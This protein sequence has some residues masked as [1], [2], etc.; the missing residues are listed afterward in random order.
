MGQSV[1]SKSLN[2]QLA[3]KRH[4]RTLQAAV[5][6]PALHAN[7]FKFHHCLP[8]SCVLTAWLDSTCESRLPRFANHQVGVGGMVINSH[9]EVLAIQELTGV[10]AKLDGFWKLPGTFVA[11]LAHV[12][13][14]HEYSNVCS[15]LGLC[16]GEK[17]QWR[18][19]RV[20]NGQETM[21]PTLQS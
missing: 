20:I 3:A 1:C 13:V 10:T 6:L 8:D 18:Q 5:F 7:G 2:A 11:A 9:N 15:H 21:V 19:T 4:P 16:A 14:V 17:E 12:C